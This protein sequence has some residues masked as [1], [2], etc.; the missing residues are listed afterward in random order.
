M[1]T[2]N[3]RRLIHNLRSVIDRSGLKQKV[4]AERCKMSDKQLSNILC[5][6]RRIT[7]DDIFNFCSVLGVTPNDIYYGD[8]AA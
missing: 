1:N 6:R 4:I 3:Y 7:A 2:E 8:N 5:F